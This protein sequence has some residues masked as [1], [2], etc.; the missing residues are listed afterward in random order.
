M[1]NRTKNHGLGSGPLL[2]LGSAFLFGASTP[3]AKLLLGI[4]DPLLLVG[5]LYFSSGIGLAC[6]MAAGHTLGIVRRE[7]PLR[8]R[9]LPWLAAIVLFGGLLGPA[10]LMSGLRLTP[11]SSGALLLNTEGLATIAIAWLVF[12]ENVDRRIFLGAMAIL[13]GAVLLSWPEGGS[14]SAQLDWGSVLIVLACISWGIDNNLTRK[15]SAADPLQIAMIKGVVAGAV[16]LALALAHGAALPGLTTVAAAAAVGFVGYGVSLVL[17]VLGLRHLGAARTGAYFSTAPFIGAALALPLFGEAP[18]LALIGAAVLMGIG[19]YLHLAE[20]HEHDHVHQPLEH[21]HRHVHDAH[22]QH[23]H[24]R[25]DPAAEP[26]SHPHRHSRI[27]HKHPHYPDL[28]H[29]H[30]HEHA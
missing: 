30:E 25:D 18:T 6:V 13:A 8:A 28:H 16:N 29:R 7:A 27:V 21:E 2:A 17:F 1:P 19:V 3:I 5:L 20:T 14:A 22:H 24:T 10:L 15:L 23:R 4:T 11:A 26:H 9:D 12:R